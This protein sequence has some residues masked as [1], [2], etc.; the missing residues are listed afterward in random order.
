A[1]LRI[2]IV[3]AGSAGVGIARQAVS[4]LVAAG[5]PIDDARA[6]C[7]LVD[8]DGLLHD[9]LEGLQSFQVEFVRP[10]ESVAALADGPGHV[11]LLA[12]VQHVAPHALVG[13][14]GQPGLFTEA[15]I[16]AQADRV[17]RPI[18]LPMSNPTPRA[19]CIPSDA[20][21]WTE[22]RALVGTGSPFPVAM[23]GVESYP[24]TQVNNLYL[25][26]GLGRGVIA[27]GAKHVSDAMLSAAATAIGS[28]VPRS[29][30]APLT[31]L[32][33]LSQVGEVADAVAL[34]VAR[35]AVA[36]GSAEEGYDQHDDE[37]IIRAVEACKWRPQYA[38]A[39][40]RPD[41][42]GRMNP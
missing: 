4:A 15:V 13:V 34:A 36:E 18:V 29:Q 3:G 40:L 10:W 38:A 9:R 14:T 32:P 20:L 35:Q 33:P 37:K 25:F 42:S 28:V 19:E 1:D 5:V 26:P 39:V 11:S 2:V 24:I 31:L 21:M 27:V 8:R 30:G 23:V 16:R 41:A 6:R 12:V 22:G 7:W 17:L